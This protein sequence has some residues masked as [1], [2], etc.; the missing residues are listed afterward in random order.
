MLEWQ[1]FST[2]SVLRRSQPQVA[3]CLVHGL[4]HGE[5]ARELKI[6]PGTVALVRLVYQPGGDNVG[7]RL[8]V[9]K[10]LRACQTATDK[11]HLQVLQWQLWPRS[12]KLSILQSSV[13]RGLQSGCLPATSTL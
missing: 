4:T 9:W 3:A 7:S 8:A 6:S 5:T 2:R 11:A 12:A 13:Q 10:A 1:T